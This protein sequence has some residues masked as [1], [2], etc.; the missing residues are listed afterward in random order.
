MVVY[1]APCGFWGVRIFEYAQAS[2]E[3]SVLAEME[4]RRERSDDTGTDGAL[5]YFGAGFCLSKGMCAGRSG[6][7]SARQAYATPKV[8][9]QEIDS[10][11]EELAERYKSTTQNLYTSLPGFPGP[12][13][14]VWPG[15]Q[16]QLLSRS[17]Y[18][19]I[20]INQASSSGIAW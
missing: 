5:E 16:L 19:T 10:L 7:L 18:L 3:I 8:V 9:A 2:C 13:L 4:C 17:F 20:C 15:E 14:P 12:G 6:F 1:G 11:T